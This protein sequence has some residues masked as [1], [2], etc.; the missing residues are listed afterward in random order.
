[1]EG[2]GL[3]EGKGGEEKKGGRG[4]APRILA[5]LTPL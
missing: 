4:T 1:M 2:K 5:G 3:K